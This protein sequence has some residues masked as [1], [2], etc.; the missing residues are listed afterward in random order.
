[1]LLVVPCCSTVAD[2]LFEEI[3]NLLL[4]FVNKVILGFRPRWGAL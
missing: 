1:M 4:A 2:S 3:S